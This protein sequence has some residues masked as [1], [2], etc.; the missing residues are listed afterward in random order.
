MCCLTFYLQLWWVWQKHFTM[1]VNNEYKF[2]M[3][4]RELPLWARTSPH[5]G[6][7]SRWQFWGRWTITADTIYHFSHR[8][9]LTISTI[10]SLTSAMA[11]WE[12]WIICTEPTECSAHLPLSSVTLYLWPR[13]RSGNNSPTRPSI[14]WIR[15]MNKRFHISNVLQCI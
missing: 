14:N 12:F 9:K 15:L 1:G 3:H 11:F 4:H 5:L 7:G 13:N 2:R 10:S 6:C 8:Q